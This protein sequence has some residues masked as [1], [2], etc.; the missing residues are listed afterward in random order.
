MAIG[1]PITPTISPAVSSLRQFVVVAVGTGVVA[2]V[3][4]LLS[5]SMVKKA[6]NVREAKHCR[7][8]HLPTTVECEESANYNQR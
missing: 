6:R 5:P 2:L 8:L 1:M 7:E 4:K 3:I